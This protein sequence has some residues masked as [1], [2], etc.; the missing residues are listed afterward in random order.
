MPARI[1]CTLDEPT[2]VS[3]GM[4]SGRVVIVM[5]GG[6]ERRGAGGRAGDVS[7]RVDLQ[8]E[9]PN[10]YF[11]LVG[12][13]TVRVFKVSDRGVRS[14]AA[15]RRGGEEREPRLHRH[16]LYAGGDVFRVF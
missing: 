11:R 13:E 10:V 9:T 6:A 12:T 16:G 3:G 5:E 8:E 4:L 1:F 14:R 15:G 7:P 2:V